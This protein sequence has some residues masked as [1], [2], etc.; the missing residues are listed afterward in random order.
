VLDGG[1][2]DDTISVTGKFGKDFSQ[3][4]VSA[5]GG[6]GNDT[7][8]VSDNTAGD[9]GTEGQNFGIAKATLS[10]GD[11]DDTLTVGGV[12]GAT[13]TGGTGSDKF[14]LTAQQYRTIVEGSRSFANSNGTNST[15]KADPVTITDF[16]VGAGGDVLDYSDLLR[17]GTLTYDG[18][19]PFGSGF[20]KLEQSGADTLLSFDADGATGGEE[21]YVV[22][23]ILKGVSK[24]NLAA[25]NFNPNY[26]PNGGAAAGQLLNGSSLAEPLTGG[27]GNDTINGLG[28]ADTIDGQAGSDSLSGG[29]GDDKIEGNF[30][31]DSL[32]GGNGNDTLTDDQGSNLLDGGNGNDNLTSRSLS[33][34]H[35]LL[36]GAGNDSLN[37]TG[38]KVSLDGGDQDDSLN[39][40]GQLQQGGST[41]GRARNNSEISPKI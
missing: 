41:A 34:D 40:T 11:G 39:A 16:A 24:D 38:L 5:L 19:N 28:G 23:A 17:N 18:S 26:P 32:Y 35:T 15:V 22:L 25:S 9:T 6:A 12:L 7:I 10:G 37:A 31:N 29:D 36:G 13:L 20:L 27:F 2:D 30:G 14:V 8:T 4:T 1:D 21:G 33:G 3:T